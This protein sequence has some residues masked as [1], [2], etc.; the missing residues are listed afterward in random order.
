M[1]RA[2]SC[3][4]LGLDM[5]GRPE[6]GDSARHGFSERPPIHALDLHIAGESSCRNFPYASAPTMLIEVLQQML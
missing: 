1:P 4:H 6:R 2:Q 5:R 3:T